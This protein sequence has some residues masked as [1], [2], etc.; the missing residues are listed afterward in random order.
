MTET[1]QKYEEPQSKQI[2]TH[3]DLAR[4]LKALDGT[5]EAE[6][7]LFDALPPNKYIKV[8]DKGVAKAYSS[9]WGNWFLSVQPWTDKLT[10][11]ANRD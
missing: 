1:K 10:V 9:R 7:R 8:G 6:Q 4:L 5:K 11:E 2:E 3:D